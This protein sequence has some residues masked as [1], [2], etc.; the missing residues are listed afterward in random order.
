MTTI[1]ERV[2]EMRFNNAQFERGIKSTLDSLAALNKGLQL[3]GAAKG[4]ND[5]SVASRNVSLDHIARGVDALSSK[6][7][8]MSVVA[9]TAL[10]NITNRAFNAGQQLVR[11]LTVDPIKAGLNEYET[12]L[13]SIQ[14]I[15]ANTAHQNTNLKQ[16]NAALEELNHYSDQTIYNFGEMA[17]NIGTFTAAGVNLEASTAAIK[18]IA[19]LAAVSGSNSQ[20]ASTA[21]YQLSQALAAGKVTLMDW[22]SVVNAGMGGKVFQDALKQTAEAHGVAVDKIIK[23]EGS[24]RDSISKGWITS[25]ILTETLSKFTGDLSEQQLKAMGYTKEQIA[26]IVK[27]GKTAQDAATKVKTVSQLIGT[28]QEAAGS[29]WAKTWQTLF[30]DFEEARTLFTN[31]NNVI[32]GFISASADARNKVLGD[33][34][35]LGGRTA[36]IEAIGNAFNALVS[37][38]RPIRDAFRQIFPPT[39]GKQLY[40]ITDAIRDFTEKLKIGADT[41]NKI[42]RTFAG[43]FAVLDIG[44]ILLT[45]FMGVFV[46]LF[47]TATK[48][49]GGIL[50]VTASL[51]D[52][53]VSLRDSV[54]NSVGLSTFFRTLSSVVVKP[55]EAIRKLVG[56]LFNLSETID[57]LDVGAV[58][59]IQERFEPLG[60]LGQMLAKVWAAALSVIKA[61]YN[62]FLPLGE[63][64]ADFFSNLSEYITEGLANIDYSAALDG[65]NTGLLAAL[66]VLFKKFLGNGINVDVGGGLVDTIKESFGALTGTMQAMQNQIKANTLLK[67]AGAIAILTAAVVAL[68]LIDSAKLTSALAAMSVMFTQ[69]IASMAL[70]GKATANVGIIKMPALAAG[71]ILLAVAIDLLAIAVSKLAKLD[72]EELAKGLSAVTALIVVLT[73]STRLMASNAKGMISAG[74][75]LILI[76][77]AIRIL[78]GAVSDLSGMSW[79][80]LAK[81]LTGVAVLLGAL[82]LFTKFAGA[83]SAGLLSGAGIVLLAAGIKILASAIIDISSLSWTEI[84]KGLVAVSIGLGAI[85]VALKLIP[86]SSL[87]SAAGVL[88]VASSLGMIAKA[89]ENMG[90]LK[91]PVIGRGLTVM[92]VALLAIS[93]ALALLPPTSLLSAAAIFI[94][95]SSLGKISEALGN[96][97]GMSWVEMTKGLLMLAGSL[98]IIAAAVYAMTGALPGAAALLVVA[99][100]LR[101]LSPVLMAFSEMSWTEMT[102]GLLMLAG[103]FTVLGVAGL[104]LTPLVP[105]LIGLGA[106]IALMGVGM[107]AA[108]AGI[109]AFSVGLTALAV[110]GGAATAAIVG[111]VSGLIGLIP[112]VMEQIGLGLVA[113]AKVISTSGPAITQAL[114]TVLVSLIDAIAKITP[115]I[116]NEFLKLLLMLVNAI[117]KYVPKLVDAG[118]KILVG[119]LN[120]I[121]KNI[122]K[123][124]EAATNVVVKFLE[125]LGKNQPR[126]VD[127]GVKTII[128]FINGIAQAIRGNSEQLGKAGANLATAI[129]EGMVKGLGAGIGTIENKAKEVARSALNAAKGVL[130]IK[131]PS[132]EFEKI[133]IYVNQG[134]IKGLMGSKG[135]VINSFNYMKSLLSDAM[136]NA[137]EDV[138]RAEERLKKLTHAR[139]KDNDE[140]KKARQELDAA[141]REQKLS[142]A[143]FNELTKNLKD[144]RDKLGNLAGQYETLTKRIKAAQDALAAAKKTRDDYNSQIRDQYDN[145]PEITGET[146]LVDYIESLRKQVADTKTFAYAIQKLRDLGLNDTVYKELLSKGVSALPF[147]SQLL[148]GGKAAV[149]EVNNLSKELGNVATGLGNSTSKALYQAAVDAAAGLVKGLEAQQKNIQKQ[150]DKIADAMVAAIKKKLGIKSPSKEFAKLGMFTGEGLSQGLRASSIMVNDSAEKLGKEAILSMRKTLMGMSK[151]IEGDM[152]ITPRITPV[153][154]LSLVKKKAAGLGDILTPGAIAPSTSY[155]SAVNIDTAVKN[156]RSLKTNDVDPSSIGIAA[157]NTYIQNNYSPK[158]LSAVEIYRQ[159]RNQLAQAKG[160][161]NKS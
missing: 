103:V 11:S 105:T 135:D 15:L 142:T 158:A 147:V 52:F 85:A 128:S 150:M 23:Q 30:G 109:L 89:I 87:L 141:R 68:S 51:G 136:K 86:P 77:T 79:E 155:I 140:I 146:K 126:I 152:D 42:K 62:A 102:K 114:V 72:W 60:R 94:V 96:M 121:A 125:A 124:V 3:A 44:R 36:A 35:A 73:G 134:F 64:F 14:T 16:V 20:Q 81:G 143:A 33:W 98:T 149:T 119:F 76:A 82:G 139:K 97:G 88:I 61:A 22:N 49:S 120:G 41:S 71:L 106:A 148:D 127:Q 154:D 153:L 50:D 25:E 145:L 66:V 100:S 69:L 4:L 58:A 101:V 84:A 9:I 107:L 55:I 27:M 29:G 115:K 91:W 80:E 70:F 132:K 56:F 26:G 24:F 156:A 47:R 75:G 92:A 34:K 45:G 108:G 39:T 159:T 6:F 31:V 13:N 46:D 54:K 130:G 59:K 95:A 10:T 151:L 21:M 40:E 122:G 99:A 129:V 7:S 5:V 112:T 28:L 117:A 78:V 160:G 2:V 111:I 83:N 48:G 1:D 137:N 12:N 90:N 65:V 63:K 116:I 131:S 133:G 113:F 18:G 67:I 53:L 93:T 8:A 157:S 19:N 138:K 104:V 17:R 161:L 74:A 110:A 43:L 37:V 57:S 118:S 123:V 32:G 144:E 38:V